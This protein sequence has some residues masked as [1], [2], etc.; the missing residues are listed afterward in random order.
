MPTQLYSRCNA[1]FR[2][3]IVHRFRIG[4]TVCKTVRPCYRTVVLPC[5]VC[6][7]CDVRALWP[8]GWTDQDETWHAGSPPNYRPKSVAAKWLHGSRCHLVWRYRRRP[9]RLCVR[10]GPLSPSPKGHI[11]LGGDPAPVP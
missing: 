9:R 6:P 2:P 1:A 11:V 3:L 8:N 4:A 7:V 10:W 5:P